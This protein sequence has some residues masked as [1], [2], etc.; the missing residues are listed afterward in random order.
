MRYEQDPYLLQNIMDKKLS[1]YDMPT[2]DRVNAGITAN[3]GA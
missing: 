3:E 2:T 1:E